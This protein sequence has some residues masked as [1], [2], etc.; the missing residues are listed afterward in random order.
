MIDELE[1]INYHGGRKM[2]IIE[3]DGGGNYHAQT[4]W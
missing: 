4:T 3:F 2:T 1:Q